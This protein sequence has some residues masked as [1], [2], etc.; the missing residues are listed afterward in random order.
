M[1]AG[2]QDTEELAHFFTRRF[3]LEGLADRI[4]VPV[5]NIQGGRD[6][7]IPDAEKP[8]LSNSVSGDAMYALLPEGDHVCHNISYQYRPLLTDWMAEQ[9][10]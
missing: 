3:S 9:L 4:I 1:F 7:R 5:L 2:K 8:R 6:A 10:G